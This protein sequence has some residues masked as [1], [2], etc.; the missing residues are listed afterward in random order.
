V[1]HLDYSG[2]SNDG[3]LHASMT[4]IVLKLPTKAKKRQQDPGRTASCASTGLKYF[5][6]GHVST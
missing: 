2:N 1:S 4:S 3:S 6:A 5:S